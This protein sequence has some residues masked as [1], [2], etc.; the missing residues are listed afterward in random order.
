MLHLYTLSC[1]FWSDCQRLPR[2][3]S[4]LPTDLSK[5]YF[6]ICLL[7]MNPFYKSRSNTIIRLQFFTF[8]MLDMIQQFLTI[9]RKIILLI[10]YFRKVFKIISQNAYVQRYLINLVYIIKISLRY[11]LMCFSMYMHLYN[12]VR[13]LLIFIEQHWKFI[14]WEINRMCNIL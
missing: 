9:S 4:F 5:L 2:V 13:E 3:R 12:W 6:K 1:L 10:S 11:S 7:S 14:G 8:P